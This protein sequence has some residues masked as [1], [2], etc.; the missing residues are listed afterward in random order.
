MG[1][2]GVEIFCML[3]VVVKGQV[4]KFVKTH[5]SARFQWVFYSK[6]I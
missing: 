6:L 3:I 4:Q 1:T 2:F 5:L